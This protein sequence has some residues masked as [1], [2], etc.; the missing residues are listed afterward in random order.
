MTREIRPNVRLRKL[1]LLDVDAEGRIA[2]AEARVVMNHGAAYAYA[3]PWSQGQIMAFLQV[4]ITASCILR[5]LF[6]SRHLSLREAI[7]AIRADR[8]VL[9]LE[10]FAMTAPSAYN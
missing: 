10:R 5:V 7:D 8:I 3:H 9:Q 2:R 1:G 4:M 6:Y